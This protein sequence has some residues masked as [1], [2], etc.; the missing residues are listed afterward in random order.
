MGHIIR[1]KSY[2][3]NNLTQNDQI[4]NENEKI[5]SKLNIIDQDQKL[6]LIARKKLKWAKKTSI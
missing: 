6:F 1:L 4:I 5:L 3:L 2:S